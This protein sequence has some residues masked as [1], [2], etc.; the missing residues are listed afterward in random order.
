MD[1]LREAGVEARS[2]SAGSSP[3]PTSSRSRRRAS[4]AVYTP[5]DFELTRIM[6]DIVELVAERAE[7]GAAA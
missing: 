7:A 3:R 5:K 1:A 6:R 4:R 2:S